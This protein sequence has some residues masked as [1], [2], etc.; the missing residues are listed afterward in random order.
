MVSVAWTL[1]SGS[2]KP[3]S[4]STARYWSMRIVPEMQPAHESS[5]FL[6]VASSGSS[7]TMS[8]TANRPPGRRTRNASLMTAPLSSARLMTQFEITTSTD[9]SGRGTFSMVPLRNVALLTPDRSRL[10][11]ASV[12]I[13]SVISTPYAWP[14]GATRLAES[15]TSRP[16][17]D[18]RS[19]TTC[20]GSRCASSVG[21]PQPR[22]TDSLS[23]IAF[24]SSSE[25]EPLHP[26]SGP[27]AWQHPAPV[28]R[29]RLGITAI[30][31]CDF[32]AGLDLSQPTLSHHM[33]KLKEAG[34]VE[35]EKRGIWMY[36][37]L[38]SDL[39]P[40]TRRLLSRLIA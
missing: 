33:S 32:T 25:Y 12:S 29:V 14:P 19:S 7:S 9:A 37:R 11:F 26:Q 8:A 1:K 36:Y 4:R 31:I 6:I 23:P 27:S 28:S 2:A 17:P 3:A 22:L 13:S 39:D 20:P 30:C 34:I 35:S 18:P 24:R 21:L 40:A 10:V 5:C 16:A 15:N 38:A